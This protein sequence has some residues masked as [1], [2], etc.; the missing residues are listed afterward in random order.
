M[1][2]NTQTKW[3]ADSVLA[4]LHEHRATLREFGVLKLGL[5]GS[6]AR[7]EE[8]PESDMDFLV[9]MDGPS[10]RNFMNLWHY[11]EDTFEVKV[12]LGDPS[13]L[14]EGIRDSVFRDVIYVEGL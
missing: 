9:E 10:F 11:L 14:R 7:G 1:S 5:F 13:T 3:D 8:T 4:Y 2:D 12:D 6:Y